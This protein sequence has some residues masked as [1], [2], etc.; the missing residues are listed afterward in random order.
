LG[1]PLDWDDYSL[2]MAEP[3]WSAVWTEI[4][5]GQAYGDGLELGLRLLQATRQ[6]RERLT[7][8]VYAASQIRLYRSILS[9]LD[10]AGRWEAY[11]R[12]WDAILART[13]LCLN[14]KGD[15]AADN[16]A[17]A[18]FVRRPDGGLGVAQLPYGMARPVRLDVHF[19]HTLLGRRAVILRRVAQAQGRPPS[20]LPDASGSIAL[21]DEEIQRLLQA[22]E[23][24]T[25]AA[26]CPAGLDPPATLDSRGLLSAA[27]APSEAVNNTC[28][29]RGREL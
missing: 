21:T 23:R 17:L 25:P 1:D 6:H 2:T 29:R 28:P 8:R 13:D 24:G 26:G 19:L 14:V 27:P 11:L 5:A 20:S 3:T 4:Q 18:A 9:M 22:G 15:A 10:K 16:P 7:A 12:A